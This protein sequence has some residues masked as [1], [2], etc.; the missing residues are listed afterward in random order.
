MK[1]KVPDEVIK[2]RKKKIIKILIAFHA[3]LY[4]I[5]CGILFGIFISKLIFIAAIFGVILCT[6]SYISGKRLR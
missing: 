4:L 2:A 3:G 6:L 5:V 1:K